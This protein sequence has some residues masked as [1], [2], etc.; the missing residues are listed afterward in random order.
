M[1]GA[2]YSVETPFT[3]EFYDVDSMQ[4]VYHGNYIKYME[5]GR[6]ALLN[7]IGYGYSEMKAS[8]Y[9]FPVTSVK[10]KYIHP[11]VFGEKAVIKSGLTEYENCLKIEYEI[12]NSDGKLTTKGE[13]TQMVVNMKTNESEMVCPKIFIDLVEKKVKDAKSV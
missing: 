13:T 12:F 8:G 6:C 7:D 9:L 11:L 2:V 4:I 3:V 10:V 5:V 1:K